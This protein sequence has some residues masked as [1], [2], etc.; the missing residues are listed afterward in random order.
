MLKKTALSLLLF[1]TS[2]ILPLAVFKYALHVSWLHNTLWYIVSF[3]F[4]LTAI[5]LLLGLKGVRESQE[6]VVKYVMGATL[7]RLTLSI[8]AIYVA[9]KIGV[10]ERLTFVLNFM[11]VYLVFLAFELYSLLTTLRPH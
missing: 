8:I 7:I 3:V 9:L 11:T 10:S 6:A 1:T 5:S 2:I 4:V